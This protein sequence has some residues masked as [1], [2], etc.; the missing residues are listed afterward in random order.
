MKAL[1]SADVARALSSP[2]LSTV[3]TVQH[4]YMMHSLG[5][6]VVPF[7]CFLRPLNHPSDRIIALPAHLEGDHEA[8]GMKWIASF[9]SNTEQG[10]QRAS[11]LLILNSPDTGYPL[12]V[13]ESSQIS[14]ARTAASG[15]LASQV[16]HCG[17]PVHTVGVIGCGTINLQTVRELAQLHPD[18]R[19]IVVHD[20][21]PH[22][23]QTFG[24]LL[25]LAH[26]EITVTTADCPA[27][28]F[29]S[30]DTVTIATTDSSHSLD[31]SELP[32]PAHQVVL[33]LSLRDLTPQ[34]ILTAAN[35]VDDPDHVCREETSL[36]LAEKIR[37]HRDF[38][39]CSL[40]DMLFGAAAVPEAK[41]IVFSPFG[42][43]VLDIALAR[44]VL[45]YCQR[46]GVGVD[47]EGFTPE[48]HPVTGASHGNL[49]P[50][51]LTSQGESTQDGPAHGHAAQDS[52]VQPS[53]PAQDHSA[54]DHAAD[55]GEV[56]RG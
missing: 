10:Q 44:E 42:L 47:L 46:H 48:H 30:S 33:H 51:D 38:I 31:L 9:P 52:P 7:S 20:V 8:M 6:T 27:D 12:A 50:S 43:G 4:A 45:T 1:N 37:G 19:T 11:A 54:Q 28:V 17:R 56:T 13:L 55:E 24:G 16:L 40:G 26:R 39:D 2:E 21:L 15:A 22:R 5:H 34:S 41:R 32:G 3:G 36:H 29:E 53:R 23:A 14:I 49:A 35:V 25:A 18:L